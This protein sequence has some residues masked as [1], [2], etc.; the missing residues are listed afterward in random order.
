V[1]NLTLHF[2]G[3]VRRVG[4]LASEYG[5]T[6]ETP[7]CGRVV[8]HDATGHGAWGGVRFSAMTVT[9]SIFSNCVKELL[10]ADRRLQRSSTHV[11][12]AL[13]TGEV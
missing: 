9:G 13:G 10:K 3:A 2:R 5:K 1:R 4:V 6:A 12:K 7:L 11:L 8:P